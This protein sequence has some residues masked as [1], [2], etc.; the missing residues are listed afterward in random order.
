MKKLLIIALTILLATTFCVQST[1]P[2][3]A[4]RPIPQLAELEYYRGPWEVSMEKVL[5][6]GS[7]KSLKFT[8]IVKAQFLEDGHTFQ[9]KFIGGNGFYSTD[10]RAYNIEEKQWDILFLNARAQRW[11]HFNAKIVDGKMTTIVKGGFSGTEEF[12]VKIIDM[13]VSEELYEKNIF[14]SKDE[15][16]TWK[17]VYKMTYRKTES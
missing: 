10:I 12:D 15:M 1:T 9:T 7:F 16:E 8:A 5:Y 11:H 4:S 13:V 2:R 17:H 3:S 6:D 14:H